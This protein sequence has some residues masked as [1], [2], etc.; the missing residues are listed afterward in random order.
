M[1]FI[2]N[3]IIL[4]I[5]AIVMISAFSLGSYYFMAPSK[6]LKVSPSH[7]TF[8][9]AEK[10]KDFADVVVV[11]K[12]TKD[13]SEYKPVIKYTDQGRYEFFHTLVDVDVL[14]VIKGTDIPKSISVA[15]MAASV[16]SSVLK[17]KKDLLICDGDFVMEKGEKYLLYLSKIDGEKYGII[18]LEQGK[19]NIGKDDKNS[20]DDQYKNLK[21]KALKLHS[22]ELKDLKD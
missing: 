6:I 1:K 4:S 17:S 18:S 8:D 11:A 13:F 5:S 15:E 20:F 9:S 3:K 16:D 10:L 7:I 21:D 2:K 19:F 12:P 14:K 22:K